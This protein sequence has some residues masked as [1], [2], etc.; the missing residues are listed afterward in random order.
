MVPIDVRAEPLRADA[1]DEF[2]I[3]RPR[4]PLVLSLPEIEDAVPGPAAAT[5]APAALALELAP[6]LM[7]EAPDSA[8]E[9]SASRGMRD[10]VLAGVVFC[11]NSGYLASIKFTT[12]RR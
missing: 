12:R 2:I 9:L 10:I 8:N 11:A 7:E 3:A 6:A 1:D 5:E 4:S